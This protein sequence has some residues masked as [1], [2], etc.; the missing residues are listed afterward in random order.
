MA[1]PPPRGA[2]H[3]RALLRSEAMTPHVLSSPL[4][5][6]VGGGCGRRHPGRATAR[7]LGQFREHHALQGDSARAL[8]LPQLEGVGALD[9]N[10]SGRSLGLHHHALEF[11]QRDDSPG[12]MLSEGMRVTNCRPCPT[13]TSCSVACT[14]TAPG[15]S[16]ICRP[17]SMSVPRDPQDAYT[18]QAAARLEEEY[19][20]T[21]AT[22]R[23]SGV[24]VVRAP[25]RGFGAAAIVVLARTDY[26]V[27]ISHLTWG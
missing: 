23:D 20:R 24:L 4:T 22:L 27:L 3:A 18:R 11:S 1:S 21:A 9:L 7:P 8:C 6:H 25:A 16:G 10:R 13:C 5:R 14:C 12:S 2:L 15:A 26:N 19:R 17:P